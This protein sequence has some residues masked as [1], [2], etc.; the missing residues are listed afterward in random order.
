MSLSDAFNPPKAARNNP[1]I[2]RR[3]RRAMR[4]CSPLIKYACTVCAIA[5]NEGAI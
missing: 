1:E 3:F 4:S 5:R 2:K